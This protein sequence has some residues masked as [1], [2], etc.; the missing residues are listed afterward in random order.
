MYDMTIFGEHV[1]IKQLY[2]AS[3]LLRIHQFTTLQPKYKGADH[4]VKMFV[5]S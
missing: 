3:S 5:V 4:A 1:H 2:Y